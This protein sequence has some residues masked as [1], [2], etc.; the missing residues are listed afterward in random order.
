MSCLPLMKQICMCAQVFICENVKYRPLLKKEQLN[1]PTIVYLCTGTIFYILG[2]FHN[3]NRCFPKT[4]YRL[5]V[6]HM[7]KFGGSSR[8]LILQGKLIK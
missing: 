5:R 6:G 7:I 2:S 8:T 1:S 4:Y 3:K